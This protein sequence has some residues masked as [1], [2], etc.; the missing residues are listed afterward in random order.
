MKLSPKLRRIK[1]WRRDCH[2]PRDVFVSF[3]DLNPSR[4]P[5][6]LWCHDSEYSNVTVESNVVTAG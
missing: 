5:L 2:R 3:L 4:R 6:P 1:Q